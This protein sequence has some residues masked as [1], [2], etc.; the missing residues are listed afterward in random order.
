MP[1]R[2]F[3]QFGGHEE[4]HRLHGSERI[5]TPDQAR[6]LGFDVDRLPIDTRAIDDALRRRLNDEDGDV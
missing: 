6:A 1:A 5:L 3:A 2:W 4:L